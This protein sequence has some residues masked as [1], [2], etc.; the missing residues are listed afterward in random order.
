MRVINYKLNVGKTFSDNLI[1]NRF[2]SLKYKII[3]KTGK[4]L[5]QLIFLCEKSLFILQKSRYFRF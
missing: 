2:L 3:H 4:S 5:L 1:N